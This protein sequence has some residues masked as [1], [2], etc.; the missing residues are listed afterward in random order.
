MM[1]T[2]DDNCVGHYNFDDL[3]VVGTVVVVV[4]EKF[5]GER[6]AGKVDLGATSYPR[7]ILYVVPFLGKKS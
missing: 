7:C 2:A 4:A 6:V 1:Y 5:A 3:S